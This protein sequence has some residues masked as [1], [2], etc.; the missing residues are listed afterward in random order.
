[1]RVLFAQLAA[2]T[3]EPEDQRSNVP[4]AAGN[5]ASFASARL[6]ARG[7]ETEVLDRGLLD[8]AGDA[9][10]ARILA[11]RA[12][13]VLCATL[14]CWSS[15]RTLEVLARA[16]RTR[17]GMLVIVGGPE[18]EKGN[19][20]LVA[21]AGTAFDL[22]AV[23]EG[24]ELLVEVLEARLAGRPFVGIPGLGVATSRGA[25][26]WA[27]PREPV[28]DLASLPS[29][30]LGESVRLAAGGIQ[31]IETAR[32]CAFEC[33]FC[34]YH[35]DFRKVRRF[36]AERV[37]SE[38]RFAL[39]RGVDDLYLMD[40]T[41]NGH[42]GYRETLASLRAELLDRGASVHTEL[43]AEPMDAKNAREIA[44]AGITSVEVGLQ[45]TTPE[46]LAA[47]GR[48]FERTRF[49]RGCRE[50]LGAGIGLEIGTIVGL[51]NDTPEGM[52]A[53][54][55]YAR[56]E[57]GDGAITVP[58]VLSLLPATVLRERAALL[59]IEYSPYPPYTL[60]R[61]PTFDEGGIRATLARYSEIFERDLDPIGPMRLAERGGEESPE[62]AAGDVLRRIFVRLDLADETQL[63][64]AARD[65]ADRVESA[66]C[67]VFRGLA[68]GALERRALA[69]LRPIREA[70]PH[71]LLEAAF[72]IDAPADLPR[73]ARAIRAALP[74]V[75]GHYWNEHLR[76]LAPPGP[77]CRCGSRRSCRSPRSRPGGEASPPNSQLSSGRP[78]NRRPRSAR[79]STAPSSSAPYCW[80][81]R[82]R[83]ETPARPPSRRS[84]PRRATTRRSCAS[85]T[86][87]RSAPSSARRVST[88]LPRRRSLFS[89]RAGASSR[90]G[91]SMDDPNFWHRLQFAF[92]A[93]YHYIFPQL[94][95]G[96][97]PLIAVWKW[98]AY[99]GGDERYATLARFWV[100]ILGINFTV[101]VVT[102]F[103]MEFQFGTNWAGFTKYSS[104]VI[105][106]TLAMEGMF[107]FFLESAFI[108]VL[109]FGEGRVSA[110]LHMLSA[111][112][113]FVGSWL[114][115]Y[116]ILVTNSFMQHPV[117]HEIVGGTLRLS[118]FGEFL[119]NPWAIVQYAHTMTAAV[120][121]G[122][123]VVTAV[124]AYYTLRGEHAD[125]ARLCL[126][127]GTAVGLLASIIVAFPA[128][129]QQAK[130]VAAHQPASLAAME[131]R[132]ESGPM[133]K[134]VLLGQPN[135]RAER[136]DNAIALPGVL[137]F[138]A[139]GSFHGD[140]PGL[141]AFPRSDWPDNIELTYYAYHV[142]IWLGGAFILLMG[143]ANIQ[144]WRGRLETS[145]RLLAVLLLSAPFPYIA[146]ITGWATA[147]LGR[148]PW[149]VYGLFRT[150]D[151]ASHAV[152]S[153]DVIFTLIGWVGLYIAL[154]I[155]FLGLIAREIS[156][157]PS[158]AGKA[159]HG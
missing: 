131:G 138:L 128:G 79:S 156:L 78:S 69:F 109:I 106:Q 87:A 38:I 147:E 55:E 119:T 118:D 10:L 139:T 121:T 67:V 31:H 159:H 130:M 56:R 126:R 61:S 41:F 28:R 22:A 12:P 134:M 116:F 44:G 65:L 9:A 64:A 158:A 155:L 94:T 77:T 18:V 68:P 57:C 71:G 92:T 54:F 89:A 133:A 14:Y 140:V 27:P 104:G 86:G 50:L 88:R 122:S 103:P 59:G 146:N 73:V 96:L 107:A 151:G 115:G 105:G 24:E 127:W 152:F 3:F 90:S 76:Y 95:M 97:A 129:D 154:A 124:G 33:D 13:D 32:G 7:V 5:L 153:G 93:I 123:F 25:V 19:A 20:F 136:M 132:F 62:L 49:A 23:G 142:M 35:A 113:V 47:V 26:E 117:G 11:E 30:Y 39:A 66:V 80:T 135:V 125:T 51:P 74:P 43:R 83:W 15:F 48:T 17:P 144:R 58:F 100:R 4:L 60:L 1:M 82:D 72:E 6:G 34:F 143:F 148:Q 85:P 63:S 149:L 8:R 108:G 70:N 101:G 102:G 46:A 53:T 45:T 81:P 29:P 145:P 141:K 91:D 99:R 16:K 98:K 111:I 114:S 112:G 84:P 75:E 137:S 120:V 110:R 157:G 21:R 42:A 2:P 37:A 40:P 36:P 52:E 150:R